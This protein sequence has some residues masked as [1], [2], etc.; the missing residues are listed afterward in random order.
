[1]PGSLTTPALP[2][3]RVNAQGSLAFRSGNR[4]G[5]G[6]ETFAAQCLAYTLPCRRFACTLASTDA[7]LGANPV[8]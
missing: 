6:E 2:C 8:R 7:W 1:M 4:V 5:S 3:T